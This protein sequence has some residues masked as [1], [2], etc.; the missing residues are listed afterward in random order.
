M[1]YRLGQ[2]SDAAAV[3]ALI[4]LT[5][6]EATDTDWI[7]RVIA[8]PTHTI[9]LAESAGELAGFCVGFPTMSHAGEKRWEID[10]LAVHPSLRG[11]GIGKLLVAKSV[12]TGRER[13]AASQRGL[14]AVGNTA[15]EKCFAAAGFA[16][17][18]RCN[19]WVN[20]PAESA[21]SLAHSAH[22]I[23]VNTVTYS[24]IWVEESADRPALL[25]AKQQAYLEKRQTVG[26]VIPDGVPHAAKELAFTHIGIYQR[27]ILRL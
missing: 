8:Q 7:S 9:W 23:P 6:D 4:T 24:G 14:I 18:E 2:P 21:E 20:G 5:W 3:G 15:S 13:G 16:A 26:A 1:N 12:Q 17:K 25:A 27:W 19:L 22:F 10:L 11:Q